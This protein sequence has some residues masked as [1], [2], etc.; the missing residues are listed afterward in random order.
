MTEFK[1]AISSFL[2]QM[3]KRNINVWMDLYTD[4]AADRFSEEDFIELLL[5][6]VKAKKIYDI[7]ESRG[8]EYENDDAGS[9]HDI[10]SNI[11]KDTEKEQ[12][13]KI[14][15]GQGRFKQE[16]IR[17]EAKCKICAL[18]NVKFLIASHIKPWSKSSNQERLDVYY[19]FL[20]CPQHDALFDKGYIT[21]NNEGKII[22]SQLLD[23]KTRMLLNINEEIEIDLDEK[24]KKYLEWHRVNK[25]ER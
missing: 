16:L 11:I 7:P 1:M 5:A 15:I 22:I 24:H 25:F 21:F 17:K 14:R 19:G 9:D 12:I 20:L 6:Q 18:E 13:I 10:D 4:T 2:G 3:M 8:N 23:K